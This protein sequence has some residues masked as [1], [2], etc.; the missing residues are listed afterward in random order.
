MKQEQADRACC[1]SLFVVKDMEA[2]ER[3][4]EENVRSIRP[5]YGLHPRYAAAVLDS[6]AAMDLPAGTPLDWQHVQR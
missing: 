5:G 1:R 2:G 3:F 6:C 4:T